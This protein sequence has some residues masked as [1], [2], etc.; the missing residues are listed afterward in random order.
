MKPFILFFMLIL[1]AGCSQSSV[2]NENLGALDLSWEQIEKKADGSTVRMFMWGG[3]EGINQYID[4]WAAPRLKEQYGINLERVP[5]DAPEFLQKVLNE[6]KAGQLEGSTDIIW[7]NGE[8]FKNAKSS[9]LLF[10]P[11][12]DKL[13]NF[14]EHVN[15][16][17]LDIQ[18]DFGE[19]SE[20]FEAP[21]GKVQFV[22]LYD[23]AKV[24]NPPKTLDDLKSW[25]EK[26]PGKFTYPDANDFTGNAF[27]RHVFYESAGGADALL[28]EGFNEEFAA[29]KSTEMWNYLNGIKPSLWKKGQTY[30][31]S[32]TELDR[33]YSSGDVWMTMGYNEA[34]AESMIEKG[35]FPETTRSFVLESGSL[36]NTHFLGIPFNSQNTEGAMTA[37]N[38]FMS[39]EA[40]L[41][42]HDQTYWGEGLAVDPSTFDEKEKNQL[43]EI[44]RGK[45]VL[46]QEILQ[47]AL[48]PEVDAQYVNWL[49]ENWMNEVAGKK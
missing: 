7:I 44:E 37:I 4:D 41:A 18:Y 20:G 43:K 28:E 32:L 25:I 48:V 22:F 23:E 6:K 21:W 24:K 29:S 39:P 12:T 38:F 31:N 9:G 10:G 16:D 8:N 14:K 13:P 45:S 49:K 30:P 11:F 15:Q 40:Q 35:I 47:E 27:L 1:A 19:K 17:A 5:M 34:R 42:K 33:L 36:G 3:D 46:P 2:P 26:N